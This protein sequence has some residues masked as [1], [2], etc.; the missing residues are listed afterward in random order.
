MSQPETIT[1]AF[2]VGQPTRGASLAAADGYAAR[3]AD[4]WGAIGKR[5]MKQAEDAVTAQ[6]YLMAEQ[7]RKNAALAFDCER[8]LR[9]PH[10]D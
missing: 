1:N 2:S 8:Q 3:S 10:T 5:A 7:H 4:E 9:V 6:C